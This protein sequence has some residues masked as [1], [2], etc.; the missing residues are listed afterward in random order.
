MSEE[1]NVYQKI[2][3][4]GLKFP[5]V[6]GVEALMAFCSRS[7][8]LRRFTQQTALKGRDSVSPSGGQFCLSSSIINIRSP[9]G[10]KLAD[11]QPIVKDW[12][13]FTLDARVKSQNLQNS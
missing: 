7:S 11:S 2:I 9:L 8:F 5:Q 12:G 6:S 3:Y 10:A 13:V 4:G 1:I